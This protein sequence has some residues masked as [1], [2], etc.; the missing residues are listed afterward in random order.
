MP[1]NR[2]KK[3]YKE[4][5]PRM[6][7]KKVDGIYFLLANL[8]DMPSDAI[9]F[10]D[11]AIELNPGEGRYYFMR[12]QNYSQLYQNKDAKDEKADDD[13]SAAMVDFRQTIKM[14]HSSKD[15]RD[16]YEAM[17]VLRKEKKRKQEEANRQAEE[18]KRLSLSQLT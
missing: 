8:E 12:G 9:P 2:E 16:T 1:Q 3:I 11:R 17:A 5:L 6:K 15:I 7:G 4:M 14:L 18:P 10:L 13:Y